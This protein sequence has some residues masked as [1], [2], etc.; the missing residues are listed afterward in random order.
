MT[1]AQIIFKRYEKKYMLTLAQYDALRR[2][3]DRKM[4][5]DQYEK[6]TI[7]NLY[8]DTDEY[9]LIRM[10]LGKPAYKEKLRMRSYGTVGEGNPVFLELKKKYNGVVYKRRV[11]LPYMEAQQ[12][13]KTGQSKEGNSQ[14]LREILYFTS[15]YPVKEKVFL[16]YD[17]MALSGIEDPELRITFDSN[18]RFQENELRLDREP[19]G[20]S[21]LD[22]GK[23][24]MEIKV[25][26]AFP[27]WL[28][29]ALSQLQIFPTSFSKYGT[30]YSQFICN[31]SFAKGGATSA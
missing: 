5:P 8:Y 31:S 12:F 10:S 29:R 11:C 1:M 28:S 23:L 25:P 15:L 19:Y 16:C 17:R 24:L 3:L 22:A 4:K 9:D 26:G 6:Y 30:C 18:I 27:L 20:I 13:L 14:I 21:I 7:C 2:C